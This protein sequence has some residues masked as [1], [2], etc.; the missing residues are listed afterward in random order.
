MSVNGIS[1][2]SS[3][4]NVQSVATNAPTSVTTDPGV[5]TG[6]NVDISKPGQLMASLSALAQSDPEKFKKVTADIAKKLEDA[7]GQ[8]GA[9][10]DFLKKLA[11]RFNAASQS[12][13]ADSLAPE[14]G[15][16]RGHHPGGGHHRAHAAGGSNGGGAPGT[17]PNDGIAALVQGIISTALG[18]TSSP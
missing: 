1:S 7:A 8:S 17:G 18:Q 2:S 9:G 4:S 13:S 12:G 6:V 10:A 11:D 3:I 16:A 14:A 5:T 15:K